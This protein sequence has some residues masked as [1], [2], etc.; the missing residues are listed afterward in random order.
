[1]AGDAAEPGSDRETRG[2]PGNMK[3]APCAVKARVYADVRAA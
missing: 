1:M 2:E 3:E